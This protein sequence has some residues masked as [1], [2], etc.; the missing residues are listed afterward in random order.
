[1]YIKRGEGVAFFASPAPTREA[2]HVL[3]MRVVL[4]VMKWLKRKRYVREDI[5]D[6]EEIALTPLEA[7]TKLAMQ[8]RSNA[9]YRIPTDVP[10]ARARTRASAV[11]TLH[12]TSG[13]RAPTS[14]ITLA[15][16]W[17]CSSVPPAMAHTRPSMNSCL[18]AA[19]LSSLTYS[20]KDIRKWR[21]AS[22]TTARGRAGSR[23][24]SRSR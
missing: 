9:I 13:R 6:N 5:G 7:L 10:V 16:S 18:T 23:A 19:V 14:R 11:N 21:H 12:R 1:M 20:R 22:K 3:V 17:G 2:L 8:D 15:A 4:R 24:T